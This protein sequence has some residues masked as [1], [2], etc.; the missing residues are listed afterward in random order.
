MLSKLWSQERFVNECWPR[1]ECR[2]LAQSKGRARMV[3][4]PQRG[5]TVDFVLKGYI[6]MKGIIDSDGFEV[7]TYH[8]EH[9]CNIG[10]SRPHAENLEFIWVKIIDITVNEPVLHTGQR[11]WLKNP[12]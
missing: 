5:D 11:T 2:R 9:S 1:P 3:Q 8:Q 7:G 6:V 10:D 4:V 12:W